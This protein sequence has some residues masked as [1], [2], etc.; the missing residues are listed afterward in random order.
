M[1]IK[2]TFWIFQ[3][4][5]R[6]FQW[7]EYS[8]NLL[9]YYCIFQSTEIQWIFLIPT[10]ILNLMHYWSF[11]W[12]RKYWS[13]MITNLGLLSYKW[14]SIIN[15]RQPSTDQKFKRSTFVWTQYN[16]CIFY[17]TKC[18]N[19]SIKS[20]VTVCT[21]CEENLLSSALCCMSLMF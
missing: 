16:V 8:S 13:S 15:L 9:K 14:Q 1:Y 18:P 12:I 10:E 7:F 21:R 4:I 6:E 5:L 3:W 19:I 2:S 17:I 11:L 20:T